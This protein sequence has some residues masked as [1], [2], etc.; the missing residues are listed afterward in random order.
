VGPAPSILERDLCFSRFV[1][2][3]RSANRLTYPDPPRPQSAALWRSP[4][5]GSSRSSLSKMPLRTTTSS[6]RGNGITQWRAGCVL[7]ADPLIVTWKEPP[8]TCVPAKTVPPSIGP[9][10]VGSIGLFKGAPGRCVVDICVDAD[11]L[12]A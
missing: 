4:D 10:V 3:A 2:M 12:S 8:E 1:S 11:Q 9:K 7:G 6:L 5:G